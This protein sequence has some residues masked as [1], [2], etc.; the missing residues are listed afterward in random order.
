VAVRRNVG[1]GSIVGLC[2]WACAAGPGAA[3][4]AAPH[5]Q[6]GARTTVVV[7]EDQGVLP[8]NGSG[9]FAHSCPAR[10]PHPVG[11]TFGPGN[12]A[13]LA[14]QFLLTGSYPVGRR[15]WR[16]RLQ[17]V[18]P[19]PQP[20]FAGTVCLGSPVRFAYPRTS[21]VATPGADSGANVSC[22]RS[23]SRA[24]GGFFR[25]QGAG[26]TGRLIADSAFRT[27]EGWDV[28]VRNIGPT[29]QGYFAGA[30]CT[31]STLRT[32]TVSRVRTIPAGMGVHTTLRCPSRSPRPVSAVFAAADAAAAGQIVATDAFRTGARTWMTGLRN[33]GSAPRRGAVGVICVR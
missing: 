7:L 13:P 23:A 3:T 8:P 25:T 9:G 26:A 29:P 2:A 6:A 19:L 15:G 16:V 20:F 33:L 18:T 22:P 21:G 17:N 12:G 28:G 10:A 5:A 1:L 31:G 11:G 32:A 4:A 14:G 27:S 24:I 30:V